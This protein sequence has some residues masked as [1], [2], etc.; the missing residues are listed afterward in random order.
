MA[1][2]D[3]MLPIILKMADK[4]SE[5]DGVLSS[6]T[7]LIIPLYSTSLETCTCSALTLISVIEALL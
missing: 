6:L 1:L 4:I 2:L 5:M 7:F 3:F